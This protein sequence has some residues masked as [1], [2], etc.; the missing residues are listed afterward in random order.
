M[1]KPMSWSMTALMFAW[2]ATCTF[3]LDMVF[4]SSLRHQV[5]SIH[6]DFWQLAVPGDLLADAILA[7]GVRFAVNW[8]LPGG[9]RAK[10]E[11]NPGS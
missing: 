6:S 8:H 1:V 11:I 4:S 9:N 10:A 7:L 2:M 3:G 5:F